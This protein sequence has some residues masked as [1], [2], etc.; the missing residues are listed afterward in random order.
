MEIFRVV[1]E[2]KTS[3]YV[4]AQTRNV[5]YKYF[6]NPS[7]TYYID[8]FDMCAAQLVKKNCVLFSAA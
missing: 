2:D 3:F 1:F 6:N 4:F 8:Q 5:F 7:Q